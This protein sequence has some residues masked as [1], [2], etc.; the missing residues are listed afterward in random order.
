VTGLVLWIIIA[1]VNGVAIWVA[2]EEGKLK[3]GVIG[4]TPAL[5]EEFHRIMKAN[6]RV[7]YPIL[8]PDS[9]GMLQT[10]GK[11][12]YTKFPLII[13]YDFS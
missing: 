5:T 9:G 3:F 7:F 11:N 12:Y 1:K 6:P 13:V 10:G 2:W 8:N 4:H